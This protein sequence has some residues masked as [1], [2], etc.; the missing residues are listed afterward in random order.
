MANITAYAQSNGSKPTV[1]DYKNVGVIVAD[2][3]LDAVNAGVAATNAAGVDTVVKIQAIADAG[4]AAMA[5]IKDYATSNN[6][7]AL[8]VKD[9]EAAGVTGVTAEKLNAINYKIGGENVDVSTVDNIETILNNVV[10]LPSGMTINALVEG[11]VLS[12]KDTP[13]TSDNYISIQGEVDNG[14][15]RVKVSIPYTLAGPADKT[16]PVY[17]DT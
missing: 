14:N 16:L 9:Y 3:N 8:T 1:T 15:H 13:N 11:T 4:V 17:S 7:T 5:K 2:A 10:I 6:G 12:I